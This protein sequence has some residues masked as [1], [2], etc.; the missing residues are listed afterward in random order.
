MQSNKVYKG[1]LISMA[2]LL[3]SCSEQSGFYID[4]KQKAIVSCKG[5]LKNLE[6]ISDSAKVRVG[7]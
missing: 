7:V 6:I 5:G 4:R 3:L 2:F 1:I